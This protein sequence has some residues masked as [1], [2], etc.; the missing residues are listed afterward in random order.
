MLRSRRIILFLLV[1]TI[2][3]MSMGVLAQEPEGGVIILANAGGDPND[4]DPILCGDTTCSR[5]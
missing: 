5:H 2:V 3:S 4:L 1:L